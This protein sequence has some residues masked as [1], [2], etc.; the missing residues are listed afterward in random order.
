MPSSKKTSAAK[1]PKTYAFID[2]SNLFYGGQQSLGWN[3]DYKKLADYLKT[4]YNCKKLYYF[5]GIETYQYDHNYKTNETVDLARLV[6]YFQRIQRENS[7]KKRL[8]TRIEKYVK[9]AKFYKK[10]QKFGYQLVLRPVKIYRQPDGS[11]RLKANCDIEMALAMIKDMPKYE[12]AMVLTGDGDFLPI[13]KYVKHNKKEVIVLARGPRTAKE[14]KHFVGSEFRDFQYLKYEVGQGQ[15]MSKNKWADTFSI[16]S[17]FSIS[18]V[19]KSCLHC[20]YIT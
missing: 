12:R 13:M 7:D 5:G 14:I 2:A 16:R 11:K 9:R 15:T 3:I 19:P 20:Q 4:R 10:L 17:T 8:V 6:R 1:E 18:I